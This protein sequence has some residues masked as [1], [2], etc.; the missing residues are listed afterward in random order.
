MAGTVADVLRVAAG[1]V[2]Y[3]RWDDPEEGTKYGRWYASITGSPYFGKSGV[4]YCAMWVSWVL[5]MADVQCEGFPRA[6]AIDARDGFRRAFAPSDSKAGDVIGFDWDSDGTG[7]HVG[8]V[9]RRD[10][11]YVTIRTY[12][13]NTG[14]GEVKEC[15]RHL[16]QCTIAVRPYYEGSTSPAKDARK[17]DVDGVAGPLTIAEWQ[18]QMGTEVDGVVSEQLEGH[19]RYRRN[20]WSV[21]HYPLPHAGNDYDG[22]QLV[23]AVQSACGLTGWM[24]DGDWGELTTNAIQ[25]RLKEWGYYTGRFDGDFGHHSVEALQQSLND[26]KWSE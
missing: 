9:K 15:V 4:P 5:A 25:R 26:G 23:R 19:D 22:S 8:I 14:D 6:V 11:D 7:D 12:E 13:G 2:G 10:G 18:R 24:V 21:D 17:L 20:V 1:E 3:S 16:S